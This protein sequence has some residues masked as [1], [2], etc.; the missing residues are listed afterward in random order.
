MKFIKEYAKQN[1]P[2]VAVDFMITKKKEGSLAT[3]QILLY[4]LYVVVAL[5]IV[6]GLGLTPIGP[7]AYIIGV[8]LAV[9]A[10]TIV[11]HATRTIC[12]YDLKY[13]IFTTNV[14]MDKTPET[15]ISFEVIKDRKNKDGDHRYV[16]FERAVKAADLFAPYTAE[17]A[18]K[19]EG[20]TETIDF[21][22]SVKK[23][24]DVYFAKYTNEDG[25]TIVI[26]FEAINKVVEKL[27]Y[28]NKEA[29]IVTKL[30]R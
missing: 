25:T 29:T 7:L 19:Y 18:D 30:S 11:Y 21:R 4:V 15:V 20:A 22:S 9:P 16:V 23:T 6:V 12:N 24:D 5:G 1:N 26:I 14:T 10:V 27:A 28:Y 13:S 2:T 3:T 8:G 17:Y